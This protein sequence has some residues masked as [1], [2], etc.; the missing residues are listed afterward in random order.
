MHIA[1][2]ALKKLKM[3]GDL[4][5]DRLAVREALPAA[6]WTGATGSFAFRRAND[7]SGK[8]AGYDADQVPIV[9]VTRGG[10]YVIEK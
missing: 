9:S 10:R 8:P 5:K 2:A 7:K 6:K 3:S 4:A 1:A